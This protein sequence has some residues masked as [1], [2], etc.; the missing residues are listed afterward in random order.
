MG[1]RKLGGRYKLGRTLGV[2][3]FGKVK[4]GTSLKNNNKVAIKILNKGDIRKYNLINSVKNEVS[5]LKLLPSHPHV[6]NL[7][8]VLESKERLYLVLELVEGG[9]LFDK[10]KNDGK[11][12]ENNGKHYYRQLISGLEFMHKHN[13]CHRDLKLEN[14]LI[15]K[16]GTLKITDFGLSGLQSG[17]DDVF[18]TT[19]GSPN[20]VAPEVL[21][22]KGYNGFKA[23]IW[24]SGVILYVLLAGC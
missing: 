8:E 17:G 15:D 7:L 16:N 5:S 24:S 21:I 2:G 1:K 23:D 13:I 9:E 11:F 20:Y 6:V 12:N 22:G 4:E 3:A 10:I 18:K 14:I 19:L